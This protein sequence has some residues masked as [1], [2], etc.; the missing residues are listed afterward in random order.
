MKD[1]KDVTK[2]LSEKA[3]R[4]L[5][6]D[7]KDRL[8]SA[9]NRGGA[10]AAP[11]SDPAEDVPDYSA[12]FNANKAPGAQKKPR[13]NGPL[14]P[15]QLS[16]PPG[17]VTKSTGLE[18]AQDIEEAEIV[19]ELI[20]KPLV[21]PE[22]EA[23]ATLTTKSHKIEAFAPPTPAQEPPQ[24]E[25]KAASL[26]NDVPDYTA[27]FKTN[28]KSTE[29]K[30]AAHFDVSAFDRNSQDKNSQERNSQ[31]RT[32]EDR[33]SAPMS[34]TTFKAA[35]FPTAAEAKP[36]VRAE[37]GTAN[38]I[39]DKIGKPAPIV[40]ET[41]P[42]REQPPMA[43]KHKS[44][45][46][47]FSST[48]SVRLKVEKRSDERRPDAPQT[49]V[50]ASG[51]QSAPELPKPEPKAPEAKAS[52]TQEH[53]S[54]GFAY[55]AKPLEQPKETDRGSAAVVAP[56]A[57]SSEPNNLNRQKETFAM[58]AK[59]H[60]TDNGATTAKAEGN[61][62][63]IA[64]ER[65]SKFSGQLKFSGAIAIDGQVEGELVAERVVVHEGGVVN[66]TVE[67]NTVIIAGTVKGDI[68]ARAELEILPSGVVH[69]S[70]TSPTISVRRGGRV[71]G[72]C[73]IGVPRQ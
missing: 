66:A 31:E 21:Q 28:K 71:E 20:T 47:D 61:V 35:E 43:E 50:M 5:P 19:G 57:V 55:E 59:P 45:F 46:G 34:T 62:A 6:V 36:E 38:K 32:S 3:T 2:L 27:I 17:T 8:K 7:M 53:L 73:A 11:T 41:A 1:V 13:F 72:R 49:V 56:R 22:W 65:N 24:V 39:E 33:S 51:L 23:T 26:A 42:P 15:P 14:E 9:F 69:G 16:Q 54:A 58:D 48:E 70:V 67:G 12:I 52:N 30:P 10:T 40:T 60:E 44:R 64:I 25:V 37:A 68:Y 29:S 4:F 18:I 63:A